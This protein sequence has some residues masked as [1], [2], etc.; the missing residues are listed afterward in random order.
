M[1]VQIALTILVA[2][3][4][5]LGGLSELVVDLFHPGGYVE[6]EVLNPSALL[7]PLKDLDVLYG[8]GVAALLAAVAEAQVMAAR[9]GLSF[10]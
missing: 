3:D 1:S 10:F 7:R 8:Q 5:V 4:E 9:L 2:Q 6:L